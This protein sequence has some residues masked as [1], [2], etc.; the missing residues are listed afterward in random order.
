MYGLICGLLASVWFARNRGTY[1][2]VGTV[3]APALLG[4]LVDL[5]VLN[6]K[7]AGIE[8]LDVGVG[9]SVLEETKEDLGGLDG[10]AGPGDTESLAY[11]S[12]LVLNNSHVCM[13]IEASSCRVIFFFPGNIGNSPWAV[14]PV[15]PAYRLMGIASLCSK[16]FP[17]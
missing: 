5:D 7:V 2:T 13:P 6:N 17:R 11:G 1:T 14:R 10:P 16:T 15:P 12:Q 3:S 8:T 9:L 4:G